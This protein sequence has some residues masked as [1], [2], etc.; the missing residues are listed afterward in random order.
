[1]NKISASKDSR[2]AN[3]TIYLL[4]D[5]WYSPQASTRVADK[6]DPAGASF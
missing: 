2:V 6:R 1:M 3:A 5:N 4:I